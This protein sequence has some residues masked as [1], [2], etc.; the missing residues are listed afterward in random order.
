MNSQLLK[1]VK[2]SRTCFHLNVL[3]DTPEYVSLIIEI[4]WTFSSV[5]SHLASTGVSGS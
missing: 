5:V 2:H 3:L 1:S 4:V